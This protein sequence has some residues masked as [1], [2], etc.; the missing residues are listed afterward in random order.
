MSDRIRPTRGVEENK[1]AD[2]GHHQTRDCSG[3][4]AIHWAFKPLPIDEL[5]ELLEYRLESVLVF[6]WIDAALPCIQ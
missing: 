5:M 2:V 3:T 6:D 1:K 4:C